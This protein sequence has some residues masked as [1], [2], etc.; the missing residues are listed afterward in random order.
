MYKELIEEYLSNEE[1]DREYIERLASKYSLNEFVQTDQYVKAYLNGTAGSFDKRIAGCLLMCRE[2][3]FYFSADHAEQRLIIEYLDFMMEILAV[4]EKV[5]C[6]QYII[7]FLYLTYIQQIGYM[8]TETDMAPFQL[9]NDKFT[10][11][12][13]KNYEQYKEMRYSSLHEMI[14]YISEED[15]I[16]DN[17]LLYQ[18]RWQHHA[19]KHF[20][21]LEKILQREHIYGS[22]EQKLEF[23]GMLDLFLFRYRAIFSTERMYEY[24]NYDLQAEI[25]SSLTDL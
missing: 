19:V 7:T 18:Y 21:L 16:A 11:Y 20:S 3:H 4:R 17:R 22:F 24:M 15:I 25:I 12:G 9:W 6:V 5:N 13:E 2:G 14:T 10:L 23:E 8:L 1:L